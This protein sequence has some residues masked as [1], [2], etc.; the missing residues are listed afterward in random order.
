MDKWQ[1]LVEHLQEEGALVQDRITVE[2]L[3]RAQLEGRTT[4]IEE[5]GCVVAF[6][7]VVANGKCRVVR[8]WHHLGS[9]ELSRTTF[10]QAS[11]HGAYE[12]IVQI[13]LQAFLITDKDCIAHL[14]TAANWREDNSWGKTSA[15]PIQL[16]GHR[17][18][19]DTNQQRR[20]FFSR[21]NRHERSENE[22]HVGISG[23][24]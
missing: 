13:R 17:Q 23:H 20:L 18:Y 9:S 5:G 22:K 11:V 7:S 4:S 3:H 14:A 12:K 24:G 10:F 2:H 21:M 1:E 16:V 6:R 15:V 8:S 19:R